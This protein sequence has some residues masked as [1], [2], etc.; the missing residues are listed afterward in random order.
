MTTW[1]E[2]IRKEMARRGLLDSGEERQALPGLLGRL[3]TP[4]P[5]AFAVAA[6]ERTLR[7]AERMAGDDHVVRWR[8]LVDAIWQCLEGD[9]TEIGLI[10]VEVSR[11]ETLMADPYAYDSP[12]LA[13]AD[14]DHVSAALYAAEALVRGSVQA[15]ANAGGRAIDAV[16]FQVTQE[17]QQKGGDVEAAIRVE[18]DPR[19]QAEMQRQR[20]DLE[21]LAAEGITRSVL[22]RLRG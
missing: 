14:H 15:A 20:A 21:L 18:A 10:R 11:L 9:Q 16:S 1:G 12:E 5:A 19:V 22:A 2:I 13:E 8:T 6:A 3:P 7:D 4:A 17:P